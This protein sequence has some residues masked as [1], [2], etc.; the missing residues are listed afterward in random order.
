MKQSQQISWTLWRAFSTIAGEFLSRITK[1]DIINFGDYM[2]ECS[3]ARARRMQ[4]EGQLRAA[5]QIEENLKANELHII[6]NF[7]LMLPFEKLKK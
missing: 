7:E 6:Q 1:V 3:M 2:L 5:K 4:L